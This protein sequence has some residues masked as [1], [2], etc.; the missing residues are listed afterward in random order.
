MNPLI[1]VYYA[2]RKLALST[3]EDVPSRETKKRRVL[4][5]DVPDIDRKYFQ[6]TFTEKINIDYIFFLL[7]RLIYFSTFFLV[8]CNRY[9]ILC[10]R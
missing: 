6:R 5:Y 3:R 9:K 10:L 2:T 7:N 8:M 4:L 1:K